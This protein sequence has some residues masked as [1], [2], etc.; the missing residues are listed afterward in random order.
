MTSVIRLASSADGPSILGI[1]ERV[2]VF[3]P[4]ELGCVEE[5]WNAYRDEGEASGY[6]FLIYCDDD[7]RPLGYVSFGPRPLTQGT[8]DLYWIAVDPIAQGH[9]VG[10]ALLVQ[11]ETEVLARG[12]RLLLIETSDTPAYTSA[13]RLYET[14]GYRCEATIH[15]FYAPGDSLL[16]FSKSLTKADLMQDVLSV[17]YRIATN[18]VPG[19]R[20]SVGG[21]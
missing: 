15:D 12:G 1:T 19:A 6:V 4:T 9:G 8:Y 17:P 10:R 21:F 7:S 13:R 11:V 16:I 3:T 2:G 14:G 5:L 20:L 18:L